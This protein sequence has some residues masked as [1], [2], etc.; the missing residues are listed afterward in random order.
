MAKGKQAKVVKAGKKKLSYGFKGQTVSIQYVGRDGQEAPLNEFDAIMKGKA[1]DL[2]Q[3]MSNTKTSVTKGQDPLLLF[4]WNDAGLTA[5]IH[6]AAQAGLTTPQHQVVA[7]AEDMKAAIFGFLCAGLQGG[8]DL[9]GHHDLVQFLPSHHH[10]AKMEA[11]LSQHTY[12]KRHGGSWVAL[13]ANAG[14]WPDIVHYVQVITITRANAA[15]GPTEL[16]SYF[17]L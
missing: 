15:V 17:N 2:V 6:T 8:T 5:R 14:Q 4:R 12:L 11:L 9:G 16:P 13:P 7:S 10:I 3:A 1:A